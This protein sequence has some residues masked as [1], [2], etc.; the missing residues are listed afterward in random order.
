MHIETFV[1]EHFQITDPQIL[2]RLEICGKWTFYE[3]GKQLIKAGERQPYLPVLVR[4]VF[5]G[6]FIDREGKDVTDSFVYLPGSVVMGSEAFDRPA[7][8]NIEA[9]TAAECLLFPVQEILQLLDQYPVCMKVYSHL[10]GNSVRRRRKEKL[11]LYC[12]GAAQRYE[13]FLKDYP[14]L[15]DQVS[16]K[17]VASFLGMTPV[18]LSRLRR[19]LRETEP[20]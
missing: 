10:L 3:K 6:Y 14:G 16:H 15:M 19:K 9:A 2:Q 4:G 18:T 7:Y 13:L 1:R 17:H 20:V 5:R 12:Y 11:I 8:I